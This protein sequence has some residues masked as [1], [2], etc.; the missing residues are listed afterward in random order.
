MQ[1]TVVLHHEYTSEIF[2]MESL[3]FTCVLIWVT[4]IKRD[5]RIFDNVFFK[6]QSILS[7]KN[8]T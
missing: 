4:L 3:P 7:L 5:I 8:A 2:L 1:N 6:I